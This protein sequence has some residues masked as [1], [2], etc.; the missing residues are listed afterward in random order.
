MDTDG[1]GKVDAASI[2]LKLK[3]IPAALLGTY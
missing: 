3:G 1:D 2:A